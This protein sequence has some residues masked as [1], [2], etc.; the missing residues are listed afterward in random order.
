[1]KNQRNGPDADYTPK[2]FQFYGGGV[3]IALPS[4][5]TVQP[6]GC[7]SA[8]PTPCA[9][10]VITPTPCAEA[11]ISETN[12]PMGCC[13]VDT[14]HCKTITPPGGK[15]ST[16]PGSWD[17]ATCDECGPAVGRSWQNM[18]QSG[19]SCVPTVTP[20]GPGPTPGPEPTP[21]P[22]PGSTMLNFVPYIL[23]GT[24]AL[25]IVGAFIFMKGR[26]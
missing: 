22:T 26:K 10:G 1:M 21:G 19:G 23:A 8:F 11:L 14:S 9:G 3:S 7:P 17:R 13:K 5:Y 6:T 25:G 16:S 24:V 12:N 20:P 4:K 2:E 18:G 15:C